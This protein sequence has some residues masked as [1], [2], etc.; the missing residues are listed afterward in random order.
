[1]LG[2]V[3]PSIGP[4]VFVAGSKTGENLKAWGATVARKH[5]LTERGG[6]KG[7][8]WFSSAFSRH[9]QKKML[10]G[11]GSPKAAKLGVVFD[12]EITSAPS[13]CW[14]KGKGPGI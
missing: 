8:K 10:R 5:V 4:A 1:V 11:V 7:G 13:T 3:L 14:R 6:R 12:S 9:H 2:K